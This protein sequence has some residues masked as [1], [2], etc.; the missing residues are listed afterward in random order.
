MEV[1][2][3]LEWHGYVQRPC[4]RYLLRMSIHI[5]QN[6]IRFSFYGD[7][8]SPVASLFGINALITKCVSALSVPYT[9]YDSCWRTWQKIIKNWVNRPV[10]RVACVCL[11]LDE[12][13]DSHR[14]NWTI[15]WH[16]QIDFTISSEVKATVSWQF[17][18][19]IEFIH[20]HRFRMLKCIPSIFFELWIFLFLH[21]IIWTDLCKSIWSHSYNLCA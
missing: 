14:H 1:E 10:V 20:L 15:Q 17:M 11:L 5:L 16:F 2:L 21:K 19:R 7:F 6:V 3:T 9:L 18:Y 8:L 4:A 13:D 12:P